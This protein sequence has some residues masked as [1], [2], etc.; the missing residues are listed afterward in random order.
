VFMN[1]YNNLFL[2]TNLNRN[3]IRPTDR[4]EKIDINITKLILEKDHIIIILD[5]IFHLISYPIVR[6]NTIFITS[7]AISLRGIL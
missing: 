3:N 7:Q 5:P 1:N 4:T 6:R 2:A